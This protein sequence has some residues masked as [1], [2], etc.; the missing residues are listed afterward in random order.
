[1]R[2]S[3]WYPVLGAS[4]AVLLPCQNVLAATQAEAR[5]EEIVVTATRTATDLSSVAESVT[6]I[7]A[8]QARDSQKEALSDLLSTVPGVSVNRNGGLGKQTSLRIRGAE[9]EHTVVLIDGVKLNDPSSP[10]GGYDFAD[11]MVNDIARIEVLRG[12][13]SVLWGS[14]AIGG[15]INIITPVPEGALSSTTSSEV[16][17]HGTAKLNASVEAGGEKLAWRLGGNYLTTDGVSAFDE[18]LGGREDDGY[19]NLGAHGRALWYLSDAVTAEVRSYWWRGTS[20]IDGFAPPTYA[21]GDTREYSINEQWVSYAGLNVDTLGGKFKHRIGTAYTDIDRE[22]ID[23][24]LAVDTTFESYGRTLRVE[25]QGTLQ[26]TD[27]LNS[28]FGAERE[29][30]RFSTAAPSDF[31]PNPIPL[32][33]EVSID[34]FYGLVQFTPVAALTLTG[35]LRYDDHETFGSNTTAQAGAAWAVGETTTLRASYGEGFK[36]PTLYQLFSEYGTPSLEPEESEDWD[37]GIEKRLGDAVVVSATYFERRTRNMI[38]FF[39]SCFSSPVP[40]CALQPY[41][42]YENL[43]RTKADGLEVSLAAQITGQLRFDAGYTYLDTTN[44][45]PG[46]G[47]GKDLRRRARDSA[48]AE[49]SYDWP[50]RLTTTLAAQYVGRSFDDVA[51]TVALDEYLLIDLRA[52]YQASDSVQLFGRVENMFDEQY[53]TSG[54]YGSLGRGVYAGF[55]VDF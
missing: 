53:E 16:G 46:A 8:Q 49:V 48:N 23:P 35:G 9:S 14:Q 11:L 13:Q 15:V 17:S 43:A 10:G 30:S 6:M 18:R 51:N 26:I 39:S 12:A 3:H 24:S 47:F 55:R 50:I 54:G 52:S 21:L 7:S 33:K 40:Q 42:F 34:S 28:V 32:R 27:A 36:A 29:K 38:D 5:A 4:C 44:D 20:D 31:D 2:L 37:V 41:G 1:M 25:Y 19:R 22:N 45:T